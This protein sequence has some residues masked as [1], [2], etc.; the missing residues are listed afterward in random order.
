M[1]EETR[2][3]MLEETRALMLVGTRALMLEETRALMLKETRALMSHWPIKLQHKLFSPQKVHESLVCKL[4]LIA[5]VSSLSTRNSIIV[6][7]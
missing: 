1:L 6:P 4:K 5:G 3:L 2:A 7:G